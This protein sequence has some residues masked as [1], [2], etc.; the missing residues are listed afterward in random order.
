VKY[1]SEYR[2]PV[3]ARSLVDRILSTATRPRV[4]MEVCGGQ[5]HT[6]VRQGLQEVLS[7]AVEMIHGP[8]CP[9]CVTPLEQIDRA[10]HL[11]ARP[12]V[13]FTSFGDM[14]RVPGSESDLL[15]VRA[16]GGEVRI[17]YSP[18]DAL[19]IARANPDREVVFFAVGF[20]TTAPA[21]AMAVWRARELGISNFSVL[22]S[23]VTVPPAIQAILD[24]PDSRV[25]AFLAAGHVCT[26]MGWKEY[27]PL[28]ETY[29][30][31]IVVTGFEP[32]DILEGI[33][34]AV[35]QL[36]DGR[37]EVENQYARSVRRRGNEPAQKLV[38]KVFRLVDRAWRGIG[39]IPASGLGLRE[40]F[41]AWDAERKF[42]LGS[43][44]ATEPEECRAG[45]V[46][47][48]HIKPFEC[49]AF[50]VTCTPERPL[51]APMVSSEGACAAYYNY[52]RFQTQSAGEPA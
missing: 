2:D 25:E 42:Q 45:D 6:I 35:R 10:L 32:V 24:A 17:V 13:I 1:L 40:E 5:T 11:A 15:Q 9:V 49:A 4:L 28:A 52:A 29:G 21:N 14:L 43:I 36:E 19:E 39:E 37:A 38:S 50:G 3:L 26:V 31:P 22:V 20:E 33:W 16:G 41:E 30:V 23:H 47:R 18:L 46:L 7:G 8:G 51:G 12:E 48:G 34:M 44:Q 27:E